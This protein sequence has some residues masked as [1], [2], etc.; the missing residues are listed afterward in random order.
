ME[1]LTDITGLAEKIDGI[2]RAQEKELEAHY[3]RAAIR[4]SLI[5][6]LDDRYTLIYADYRDAYEP[7]T[8]ATF[9]NAH[10]PAILDESI[11]EW[12]F[13][14][15]GLS[16]DTIISETYDDDERA[17]ID[18]LE[19][20]PELH[21]EIEQRDDS[22]PIKDLLKN[23]Q[24]HFCYVDI[25]PA[26]TE[27]CIES[28]Q[29]T[30]TPVVELRKI[31]KASGLSM[32]K[33]RKAIEELYFNGASFSISPLVWF[34]VLDPSDYYNA[35]LAQYKSGKDDIMV[36]L[37]SP[38]LAIRDHCNGAGHC[39]ETTR[40][41]TVPLSAIKS[42]EKGNGYSFGNDVC[43]LIKSPFEIGFTF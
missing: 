1:L 5:E 22:D 14:N 26:E 18:L 17:A 16:C 42:D 32:K 3:D 27:G 39:I 25:L 6:K 35:L 4:E 37:H 2:Q 19:L 30:S 23:S 7:E 31:A 13:E 15:R 10:D 8:I 36:T 28:Y 38:H 11:D 33:D 24:A 43:G 29:Y 9:I 21:M 40:T 41:V 20:A 12:I 34:F